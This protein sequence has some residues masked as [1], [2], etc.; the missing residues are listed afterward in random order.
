MPNNDGN[1]Q[2]GLAFLTNVLYGVATVF[3]IV[4]WYHTENGSY[5]TVGLL[6]FPV[7]LSI[8]VVIN[9]HLR[10]DESGIYFLYEFLV[11]VLFNI[12]ALGVVHYGYNEDF[13]AD[14]NWYLVLRFVPLVF[15]AI[16]IIMLVYAV[17]HLL[18]FRVSSP[19]DRKE[20]KVNIADA[21]HNHP[22]EAMATAFAMFLFV[23]YFLAYA[24]AFDDR[25]GLHGVPALEGDWNS[26][27]KRVEPPTVENEDTERSNSAHGTSFIDFFI[28]YSIASDNQVDSDTPCPETLSK[29]ALSFTFHNGNKNLIFREDSS[30]M[31][32]GCTDLIKGWKK[33][34]ARKPDNN[35]LR[36]RTQNSINRCYLI[37]FR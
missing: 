4:T 21:V 27:E 16:T 5:F 31:G 15:V 34:L 20:Q 2:R 12:I 25:K 28:G 13:W 17:S 7:L 14:N 35:D 26:T 19:S 11:A 8:L 3:F 29:C 23:T 18:I 30:P 33:T 37:A 24:I 22:V 36:F 9:K 32:L 6:L 10:S 1:A